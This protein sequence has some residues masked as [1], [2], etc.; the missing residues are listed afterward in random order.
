VVKFVHICI[1]KYKPYIYIYEFNHLF[2]SNDDIGL[3]QKLDASLRLWLNCGTVNITVAG[4]AGGG[5]N[6]AYIYILYIYIYIY[7]IYIYIYI[8]TH[9]YIYI[10]IYIL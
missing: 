7:Y 6:M 1:Y 10:Y 2:E 4:A 8:H 3:T 9:I 5:A